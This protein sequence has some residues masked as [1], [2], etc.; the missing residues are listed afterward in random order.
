M[1]V[2]SSDYIRNVKNDSVGKYIAAYTGG[3]IPTMVIMSLLGMVVVSV[4]GVWSPIDLFV[5]YVPNIWLVA[6]AMGFIIL[7]Q[8]STNMFANIIPANLVW[9][10]LFKM[11]WLIAAVFTGCLGLLIV[12]WYLTTASGFFRFMN[13]YGAML[14]PIGGIMITDYFLIRK[15]EFNLTT[16]YEKGYYNYYKG[17]NPAGLIALAVGTVVGI[18][19]LNLSSITGLI[20]G[21]IVYWIVQK[22]WIEKNS[23]TCNSGRNQL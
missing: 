5:K 21:A 16:L 2:N 12:P 18:W 4:S 23:V 7:G 17:F 22:I 8:F 20:T 1:V 9:G 15:R 11:P 13:L 14:G 19:N 10:D 3:L 6:V